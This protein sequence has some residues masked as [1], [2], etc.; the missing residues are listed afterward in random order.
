MNAALWTLQGLLAALFLF[1]GVSKLVMPLDPIAAQTGLSVGF[2]RFIGVAEALGSL[3]L[4]L[5]GLL[6]VQAWLTPL[7]AACLVVV[8]VGAVVVSARGG[9]AAAIVPFVTGV[10]CVGVA[11]GRARLGFRPRP[12]AAQ[13]LAPTG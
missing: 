12:G 9:V 2:L 7:A 4:V 11:V 6:R 5:P 13:T 1:A 8:M 3:G 10:L